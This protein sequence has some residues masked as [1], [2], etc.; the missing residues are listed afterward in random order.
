M[1]TVDMGDLHAMDL[2]AHVATM[3]EW[4]E[5]AGFRW[6]PATVILQGFYTR[7]VQDDGIGGLH[8]ATYIT[9]GEGDLIS[10]R[11]YVGRHADGTEYMGN[12]LANHIA[13]M[14]QGLDERMDDAGRP[15]RLARFLL[16]DD[17]REAIAN[18]IECYAEGVEE[19]LRDDDP[20][21]DDF[22]IVEAYQ[23][24]AIR[25]RAGETPIHEETW[26]ILSDD[27][28]A[29]AFF[30]GDHL[31]DFRETISILRRAAGKR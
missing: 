26:E 18:A 2:G 20:G 5:E 4:N 25:V 17:E 1:F 19:N 30:S 3:E 23:G 27:T 29:E 13:G 12:T 15:S 16:S 31:D 21:R 14:R 9:G 6:G 10:L 24:D 28:G 11:V 22:P 7:V 8:V